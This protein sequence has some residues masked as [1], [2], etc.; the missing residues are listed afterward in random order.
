MIIVEHFGTAER[1]ELGGRGP[2]RLKE[3]KNFCSDLRKSD[4]CFRF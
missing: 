2:A 1:D 3:G 4:N